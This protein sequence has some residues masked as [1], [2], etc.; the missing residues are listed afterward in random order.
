MFNKALIAN[1]GEIAARIMRTC[2]R[3]GIATVAVYSDADWNAPHVRMAGEAV[4]LG[5]PRPSASYLDIGKIVAAAVATGAQAVHP[6]YG[7]VS[8]NPALPEA[9]AAAAIAFVGPPAAA[10]RALGDKIAARRLAEAHGVP[11]LPGFDIGDRDELPDVGAAAF[12]LMLKAAAGGGGR[13]MRV[14]EDRAALPEALAAARREAAA[15]FGDGRLFAERAVVGGRHIEVQVI[16]DRHGN[17]IHLGERDCSTQRRH[18]KVIEETPAPSLAPEAR[19]RMHEA[20]LTM[21][22]A[23]GYEN[24]GTVEFLVDRDGAFY[25]LEV[26]ARLQ[27]EHPVTEMVTGVDLVELQLRVASGEPLPLAQADV[28][29]GGHAIE[30]RLLAE[31]PARNYLPASGRIARFVA[32]AMPGVRVDSG[33]ADGSAAPAEYDSLLAKI[34]AHAPSRDAAVELA[35]RA[36]SATAVEGVRTNAGLLAAVLREPSFRAGTHGLA[37]LESMP[38]A[39]FAPALPDDALIA[40]AA[41]DLAPVTRADPWS[42]LGGWRM[43]GAVALEYDYHGRTFAITATRE[44]GLLREVVIDGRPVAVPAPDPAWRV[45]RDRGLVTVARGREC[46]ALLRPSLTGG[47]HPGGAAARAGELRAPMPGIVVRIMAAV[48]DRVAARQPLAVIEAMK[49]EHIIE[50]SIDGVVVRIAVAEGA[51]VAEGDI[52][53]EVASEAET[54]E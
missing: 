22:R 53:V 32:P 14:V 35:G 17:V 15:A 43:H 7:F 11:V 47:A 16:A 34:I 36:L 20:A 8:E 41:A 25:F 24:A 23:A 6:G 42:A 28:R 10:M 54:D 39:S 26:N 52:L 2:D 27:V 3:M 5:P 33:V 45:E 13:G 38:P 40:A 19:A 37:L 31:D 9:C 18:Q 30:V 48:G 21:A 50:S 4:R 12:P 44:G 1:R 46:Y 29:F 51:R 49:M